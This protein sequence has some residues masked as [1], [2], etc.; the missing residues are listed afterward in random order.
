MPI[1]VGDEMIPVS[2][3]P[4]HDDE[5]ICPKVRPGHSDFTPEAEEIY[6]YWR[7]CCNL[8]DHPDDAWYKRWR[9]LLD[10]VADEVR[11]RRQ[12]RIRE[13]QR[14]EREAMLNRMGKRDQY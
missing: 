3:P 6:W 11:H 4:C 9:R 7:L 12:E 10:G 5:N 8:D 2:K 1:L 14:R 13:E